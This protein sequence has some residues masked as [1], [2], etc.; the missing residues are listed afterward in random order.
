MGVL[1]FGG[2]KNVS[3]VCNHVEPYG[4]SNSFGTSLRTSDKIFDLS[5]KD[6]PKVSWEVLLNS[7]TE[8]WG[9]TMSTT[10][11]FRMRHFYLQLRSLDLRFIFFTYGGGTVS[12]KDQIQSLAGVNRKQERLNQFATEA[13]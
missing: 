12:K 6:L 1:H 5:A 11:S 10:S 7:R 9:Q 2:E 4:T 13:K 8:T 3:A